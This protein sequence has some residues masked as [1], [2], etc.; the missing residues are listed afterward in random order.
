M[1]PFVSDWDCIQ[2]QIVPELRFG[3]PNA[4]CRT[5]LLYYGC[6]VGEACNFAMTYGV[7]DSDVREVVTEECNCILLTTVLYPVYNQEESGLVVM[8]CFSGL[9]P[10]LG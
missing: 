6:Q 9:L 10:Y 3:F 7:E 8:Y 2:G 1:R 5:V 4:F